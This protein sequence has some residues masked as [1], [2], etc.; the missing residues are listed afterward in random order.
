MHPPYRQNVA[1]ISGPGRP[2]LL[3]G[4]QQLNRPIAGPDAD[5]KG[6]KLQLQSAA[7][8]FSSNLQP[9]ASAPICSPKLQL[10]SAAPIADHHPPGFR[11]ACTEPAT[12]YRTRDSAGC[13]AADVARRGPALGPGSEVPRRAF[14]LA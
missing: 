3:A 6:P 4:R 12:L 1:R 2:G 13:T 9:E 7:R 10:Q 8:S 5:R 14:Q 11:T